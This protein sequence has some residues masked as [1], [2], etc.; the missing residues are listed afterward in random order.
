V[1]ECESCEEIIARFHALHLPVTDDS[2]RVQDA[3]TR[4]E[5]WKARESAGIGPAGTDPTLQGE[6]SRWFRAV[7]PLRDPNKVAEYVATLQARFWDIAAPLR[8]SG[9]TSD[10]LV[11]IAVEQFG[12]EEELAGKT[13][14]QGTLSRRN[15]HDLEGCGNS[16]QTPER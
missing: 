7:H 15:R 6:A 4:T 14:Q 16:G 10:L 13:I 9:A 11:K 3:I 1:T 8:C 2:A 5:A 12:F